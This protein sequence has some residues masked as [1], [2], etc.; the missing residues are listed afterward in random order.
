MLGVMGL[1][2]LGLLRNA[3][4]PAELRKMKKT[5]KPSGRQSKLEEQRNCKMARSAHA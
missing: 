4:A 2:Y 5:I 1:I 3:E